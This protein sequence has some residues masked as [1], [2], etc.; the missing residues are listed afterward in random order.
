VIGP[1]LLASKG[2]FLTRVVVEE[3]RKCSATAE[4]E[5]EL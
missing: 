3:T 5:V 1:S 4:L 2:C